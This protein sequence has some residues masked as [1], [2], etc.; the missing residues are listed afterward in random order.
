MQRNRV[1]RAIREWFRQAKVELDSLDVV[2][3]ARR[4]AAGLAASEARRELGRL[5]R[6]L[7]S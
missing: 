6:E 7:S 3:I 4:G 1:K 5:T 2:V